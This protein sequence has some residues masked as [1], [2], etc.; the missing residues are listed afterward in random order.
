MII[1]DINYL[2]ESNNI[3]RKNIQKGMKVK[4]VEKRDQNTDNFTIGIVN[5]I[6]TSK[7]KHTRGIKVEILD[8]YN[9]KKVGRVQKILEN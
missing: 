1:E 7:Q 9:N 6:L 4:I 8:K 3:Y 2:I 5:K